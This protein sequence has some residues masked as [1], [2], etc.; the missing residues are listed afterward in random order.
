MTQNEKTTEVLTKLIKAFVA[1]P[2]EIQIQEFHMTR[3]TVISVK[4]SVKDY[5][6]V[7]GSKAKNCKALDLLAKLMGSSDDEEIRLSIVPPEDSRVPAHERFKPNPKWGKKE[8]E[9]LMRSLCAKVFRGGTINIV[10]TDPLTL[11][12]EIK[13]N[14]D[15]TYQVMQ[16][17]EWISTYADETHK[18]KVIDTDLIQ[19]A[20]RTVFSAIGKNN[21][22]DVQVDVIPVAYPKA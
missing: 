9:P 1:K 22:R 4:T 21:G 3:A 19:K 7:V 12:V 16:D 13:V 14:L 17:G 6:R 15:D 2:S 5:G 18:P 20:I 10:E 8:I 11:L